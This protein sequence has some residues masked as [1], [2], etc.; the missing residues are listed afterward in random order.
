MNLNHRV[1]DKKS[2]VSGLVLHKFGYPLTYIVP[3]VILGLSLFTLWPNFGNAWQTGSLSLV[4]L[5]VVGKLLIPF[6]HGEDNLFLSIVI[7]ISVAF[8]PVSFYAYVYFLTKRH[9]PSLLT[10][11]LTLLPIVPFSTSV[12]ERLILALAEYDGAH[13]L[14]LSLLPWIAILYHNYMRSGEKKW[15][16]AT[17]VLA[18]LLGLISFF[19]F[20][21]LLVFL[22]FI[23][24]SEALVSLGRVKLKRFVVTALLLIGVFV[25]IYNIALFDMMRSEAGKVTLAVMWNL[26]PMTFFILPIL[27]TFAFLIFDRRPVLQPLFLSLGFT[28]TFGMLHLVRISFVEITVFNQSRYAAE[29]SFALAFLVGILLMW[30]FDL[31]R[32]GKLVARFPQLKGYQ[33]HLAYAFILTVIG[34]LIASLLLIPR[35]L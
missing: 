17:I 32:G 31:I 13:I 24:I 23:S 3:M 1:A 30:V 29:V 15:Q 7:L 21:L 18:V 9:L 10:G 2:P 20:L 12:S 4:F 25:A 22:F 33:I 11:L 8:G 6:L 14:G 35:S 16:T 27:G 19:S 28:V 34:S 5:P 26:L